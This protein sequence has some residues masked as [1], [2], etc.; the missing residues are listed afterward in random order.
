MP[1]EDRIRDLCQ[2][3][4]AEGDEPT[5][6]LLVAEL[7]SALKEFIGATRSRATGAISQI[8]AL[9]TKNRSKLNVQSKASKQSVA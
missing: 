3:V 5:L 1:S 8:Q 7:Q 4:I 6:R 9:E 2:R